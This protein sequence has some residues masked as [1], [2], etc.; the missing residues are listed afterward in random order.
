MFVEPS[1]GPDFHCS[2]VAETGSFSAR[3]FVRRND[4]VKP[5]LVSVMR[6]LLEE[7]RSG[8]VFRTSSRLTVPA[9]TTLTAAWRYFTRQARDWRAG[10]YAQRLQQV[11]GHVERG[12]QPIT[13]STTDPSGGPVAGGSWLNSGFHPRGSHLP[14][15]AVS[16]RLGFAIIRRFSLAIGVVVG[17][18]RWP[19]VSQS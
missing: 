10:K 16:G 13:C 9:V 6:K 8:A 14:T 1:A 12:E 19:S 15:N 2:S 7:Y 18:R 17:S 4:C 5:R 3:L 11:N